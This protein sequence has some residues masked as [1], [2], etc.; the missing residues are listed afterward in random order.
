MPKANFNFMNLNQ[1]CF[2]NLDQIYS[3]VHLG[4]THV[5]F[6][7]TVSKKKGKTCDRNDFTSKP[8]N[9]KKIEDKNF[10]HI[11]FSISYLFSCHY[12]ILDA[13]NPSLF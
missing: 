9:F 1:R 5:V 7:L 13:E 6:G 12:S 10:L 4:D 11:L 8:E 2:V 3:V